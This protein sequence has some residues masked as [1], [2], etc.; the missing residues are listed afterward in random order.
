MAIEFIDVT[1][2]KDFVKNSTDITVIADNENRLRFGSV[3]V[4]ELGLNNEYRVK[5]A[6]DGHLVYLLLTYDSDNSIKITKYTARYFSINSKYISKLGLVKGAKYLM[7][8]TPENGPN[9][10]RLDKI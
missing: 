10:Y 6:K 7:V 9:F 2:R 1:R 3:A 4:R 8:P 5:I